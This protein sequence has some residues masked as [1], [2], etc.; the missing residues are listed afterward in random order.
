MA[1]DGLE[2][3]PKNSHLG[4]SFVAIALIVDVG[5]STI[6]LSTARRP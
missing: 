4:I 3:S 6:N 2:L 5:E 1:E